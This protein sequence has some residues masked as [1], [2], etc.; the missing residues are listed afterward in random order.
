MSNCKLYYATFH[1][2]RAAGP[3]IVS[4]CSLAEASFALCDL[5]GACSDGCGLRR[6]EFEAGHA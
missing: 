1:R 4:K 3:V 6:T 2:A 5:S